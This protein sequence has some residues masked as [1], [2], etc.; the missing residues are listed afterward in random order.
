LIALI[1]VIKIG[2]MGYLVLMVRTKC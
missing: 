2:D 1:H